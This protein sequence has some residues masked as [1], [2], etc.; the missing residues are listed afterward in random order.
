MT[1]DLIAQV[2]LNLESIE[3]AEGSCRETTAAD[4]QAL[5]DRMQAMIELLQSTQDFL[6]KGGHARPAPG[7]VR[8]LTSLPFE[9]WPRD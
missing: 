7:M 1:S 8:R 9:D 4:G 6:V 3:L 5:Y 2:R